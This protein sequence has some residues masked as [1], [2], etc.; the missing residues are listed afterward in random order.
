MG[1]QMNLGQ[2]IERCEFKTG[3]KDAAYRPRWL[4]FIDEAIREFARIQPWDGLEDKV[5]LTADAGEEFLVLPNYVDQVLGLVNISDVNVVDRSGNFD[6]E[7][8]AAY[9]EGTR[10]R[11]WAYDRAGDVPTTDDPV[12]RI[13]LRSSHASDVGALYITGLAAQSGASGPL[14]RTFKE[15]SVTATGT[16]PLTLSV[17]FTKILSVSK[18]TDSN[19]EFFFFDAGASNKH[20]AFLGLT[21]TES[22]FKRLKLFPIPDATKT[23][24]LRFRYKIPPLRQDAQAPHP[25]VK[26]DFIVAYAASLHYGEQQ[27]LVKQ[28][29]T[30][31]RAAQIVAREAH[32]DRNFEEPWNQIV[33]NLPHSSDQSDDFYFGYQ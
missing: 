7:E 1:L 32:K 25:A 4:S 27:Q 20:L 9:V 10:G 8:T 18:A 30:E 33:P 3:Y 22:R 21:D 17:L 14:E 2:L 28:S 15:L 5:Q 16:S 6:R 29:Q 24:E 23:L 11:T 31:A 12:G 13:W 19:G 26:D